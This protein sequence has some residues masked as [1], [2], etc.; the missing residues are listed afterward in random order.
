MQVGLIVSFQMTSLSL[1]LLGIGIFKSARVDNTIYGVLLELFSIAILWGSKTFN[2]HF[3]YW[4]FT[5]K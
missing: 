2:A 3:T 4:I 5:E 1:L